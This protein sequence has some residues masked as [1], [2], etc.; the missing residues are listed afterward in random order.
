MTISTIQRVKSFVVDI[1]I[2]VVCALIVA[3]LVQM[4]LVRAFTIPS[5]SM[6]DTLEVGDTILVNRIAYSWGEIHR[7]DIV[8]FADPDDWV[9]GEKEG[10][11]VNQKLRSYV[12]LYP[13]EGD[14]FVVKRVIG[15]PGDEVYSSGDG[16]VF[17]N[18]EKL[19][20]PYLPVGEKGSLLDFHVVVPAGGVWVMGDNR[21]NSMDSRVQQ[22]KTLNGAVPVQNI[23][24]EVFYYF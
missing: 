5:S 9:P 10:Y 3:N 21:D 2:V 6:S 19:I 11:S 4:F 14:S 16:S 12:G 20:E 17:V 22:E 24:G 15:L 7:G 13:K 18:G 1:V 8:V 23:I